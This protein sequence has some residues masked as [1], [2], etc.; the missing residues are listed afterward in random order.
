[1]WRSFFFKNEKSS[2]LPLPSPIFKTRPMPYNI[3]NSLLKGFRWWGGGSLSFFCFCLCLS[4]N[5]Y[6]FTKDFLS[7]ITT[8]CQFVVSIKTTVPVGNNFYEACNTEHGFPKVNG[9]EYDAT[10]LLSPIFNSEIFM[11]LLKQKIFML[12]ELLGI[13][14]DFFILWD[15][16]KSWFCIFTMWF[17]WVLESSARELSGVKYILL[18]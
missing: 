2:S 3:T 1:M 14:L 6:K 4:Q 18:E 10:Q 5:W 16:V 7:Q 8:F 9:P 12:L 15:T 17:H 13:S 11:L